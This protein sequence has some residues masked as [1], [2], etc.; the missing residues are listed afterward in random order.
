MSPTSGPCQVRWVDRCNDPAERAKQ[1]SVTAQLAHA[2]SFNLP[3]K[4]ENQSTEN[5]RPEQ[6]AESARFGSGNWP[7]WRW[8]W[9]QSRGKWQRIS[10]WR[11]WR[12]RRCSPSWGWRSSRPWRSKQFLRQRAA[13]QG[14]RRRRRT[15]A[16]TTHTGAAGGCVSISGGLGLGKRRS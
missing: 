6:K 15:G 4:A 8:R 16:L 7:L 2:F 3:A 5:Q 9:C 14:N 11:W 13:I 10:T 1:R 12:R